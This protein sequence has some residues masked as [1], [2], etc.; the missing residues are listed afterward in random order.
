MGRWQP[1]VVLAPR[2]TTCAQFEEVDFDPT[3]L[4]GTDFSKLTSE[5]TDFAT[6]AGENSRI[7]YTR[8]GANAPM[9]LGRLIHDHTAEL[10]DDGRIIRALRHESWLETAVDDL[11]KAVRSRSCPT[12]N[13]PPGE[14]TPPLPPTKRRATAEAIPVRMLAAE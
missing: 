7:M 1:G 4:A 12:S 11:R 5:S 2:P 10:C 9:S 8:P 14:R 13:T 3:K 6:L